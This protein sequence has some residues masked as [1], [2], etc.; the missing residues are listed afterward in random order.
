MDILCS[1]L[2]FWNSLLSRPGV[3]SPNMTPT[4]AFYCSHLISHRALAIDQTLLYYAVGM[5][6]A[7]KYNIWK[8]NGALV[9]CWPLIWTT[10]IK[11]KSGDR[12]G[13]PQGAVRVNLLSG[14]ILYEVEKSVLQSGYDNIPP[15]VLLSRLVSHLKG[16]KRVSTVI[17][18]CRFHLFYNNLI[19]TLFEIIAWRFQLKARLW[20]PLNILE[21]ISI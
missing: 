14:C 17:F 10:S 8:K 19:K 7:W 11:V 2:F 21:K 4:F 5:R 15:D 13:A 18:S 16:K 3:V 12:R 1:K 6:M 9:R 20:Y